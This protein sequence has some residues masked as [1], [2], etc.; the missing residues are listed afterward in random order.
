VAAL[1]RADLSW[2]ESLLTP[3]KQPRCLVVSRLRADGVV[4][5]IIGDF[6][7][8]GH[9]LLASIQV[10]PSARQISNQSG[11]CRGWKAA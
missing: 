7:Y 9:I 1:A 3:T 8:N 11:K 2:C 4:I 6:H 10:V 5:P